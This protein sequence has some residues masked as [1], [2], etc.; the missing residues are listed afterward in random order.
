MIPSDVL[1]RIRLTNDAVTQPTTPIQK[2]ADALSDFVPGQ[3]LQAEIMALLPNG[4]YRAMVGQREITLALPFSAKSGDSLE[5][6]VQESD[7]K[8]VLAFVGKA[9]AGAEAQL[10]KESFASTFS[11]TGRLIADLLPKTG[12]KESSPQPTPLN[13][14][15]PLLETPPQNAAVLAPVLKQAVAQSGMFY[16]AHQAQWVQ[17]QLPTEALLK[18][19]QGK[20]SF[21]LPAAPALAA[22]TAQGAEA[23]VTAGAAQVAVNATESALV[24]ATANPSAAEG[25]QQAAS[26]PDLTNPNNGQT[27]PATDNA[28][29]AE[30]AR[31]GSPHGPGARFHAT[32]ADAAEVTMRRSV[33]AGD[34]HAPLT[35]AAAPVAP[36]VAPLVQNQLEALATQ[37]FVWQGQVWPGQQ[38]EWEITA[39]PDRRGGLD[40]GEPERWQTRVKLS[41]PS[42]G[43]VEATLRLSKGGHLEVAL[44][45]DQESTRNVLRLGAS[46]L[47]RH[48]KEA[49]LALNNFGVTRLDSED[50]QTSA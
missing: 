31:A 25:A 4:S 26:R 39:N 20:L 24:A 3:K 17:G 33:N 46:D 40:E 27:S 37:N 5:L 30:Q 12:G 23:V 49:G 43:G 19:P 35:S 42:L 28:A 13:G 1:S 18:E 34:G 48:L 36:E 16:E 14:S 45:A 15:T 10:P 32:D 38:M 29:S 21:P 7:G 41:L 9:P 47:S 6:E 50:E 11:A 8:L 22:G 2:L 44:K